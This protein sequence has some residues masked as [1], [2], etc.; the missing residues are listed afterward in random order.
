MNLCK[1]IDDYDGILYVHSATLN[2]EYKQNKN[3]R[4]LTSLTSSTY[5][6]DEM[7]LP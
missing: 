3:N 7:D 2:D 4:G 5:L 1:A 6:A